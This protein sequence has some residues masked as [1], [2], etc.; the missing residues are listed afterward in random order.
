MTYRKLTEL[1]NMMILTAAL[2]RCNKARGERLSR[3]YVDVLFCFYAFTMDKP[4]PLYHIPQRF[5]NILF[6]ATAQELKRRIDK[7]IELGYVDKIETG[8][9][10][11]KYVYQITIAGINRI[12]EMHAESKKLLK[13]AKKRLKS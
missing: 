13:I 2:K 6:A 10:R 12:N 5:L 8:R 1:I 4:K 11:P 3:Q 9:N 7:L